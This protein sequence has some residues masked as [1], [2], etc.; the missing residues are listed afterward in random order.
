MERRSQ[1]WVGHS[2]EMSSTPTDDR[3]ALIQQQYEMKPV[4]VRTN[5]G[6]ELYEVDART[7]PN[8]FEVPAHSR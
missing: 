6:G 3:S 1:R 8:V 2:N 7:K 4:P 5:F